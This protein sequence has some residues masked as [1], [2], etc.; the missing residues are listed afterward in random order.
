MRYVL[1]CNWSGYT[2]SQSRYCHIEVITA[3][4]AEAFKDIG[5]IRFG[6]NTRMSVNVRPAKYREKVIEVKGYSELLRKVLKSGLKGS[7]SVNDLK[8]DF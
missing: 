2:S 8:G 6:D 1:E 3:K 5:V 7:V 4:R